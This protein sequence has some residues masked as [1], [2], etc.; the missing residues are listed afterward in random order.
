MFKESL[1]IYRLAIQGVIE[2][3]HILNSNLCGTTELM[4]S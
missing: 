4:Q 1:D 2:Y 3:R